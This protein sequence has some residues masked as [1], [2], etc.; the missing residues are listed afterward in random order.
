MKRIPAGQWLHFEVRG[1]VSEDEVHTYLVRHGVVGIAE[2]DISCRHNH[3]R[4]KT[5]VIISINNKNT[6]AELLNMACSGDPIY[7]SEDA[8][9]FRP[10]LNEGSPF[11]EKR[12]GHS[13]DE[14]R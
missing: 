9:V 1:Y 7:A 8:V 6:V 2:V 12:N 11:Y 5:G 13:H 3:N 4:D 14:A 10:W